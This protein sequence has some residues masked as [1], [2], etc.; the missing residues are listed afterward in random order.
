MYNYAHIGNLRTYI[1]EDVLRRTLEYHGYKTRHI[2]NLTDVDDKTIRDSR[3]AGKTLKEFTEFYAKEFFKDLAKL[4]ILRALKYPRATAHIPEMI[5]LINT[6]LKRGFAYKTDDG[7]YFDISKFK[8]YGKLSGVKKQNLKTGARVAADEY[9][10][11]EARDFALWKAKKPG[12]P[13]WEASFNSGGPASAKAMAGRPGWHIEC[14]AMSMKYLDKSFDI[15]AGAVDLLFP[16]HEDEIAQSEG[17]TGKQFVKYFIEGEHLLV[18]GKK[19]SKSL[20]NIYTMR[21]LAAKEFNPLDFR[22]FA[23]GAH[24]RTQLNFTW[25]A[26]AAAGQAR[27][28][29]DDFIRMLA[30]EKKRKGVELKP[31]KDN[32]QKSLANDI[33]T[34]RALAVIWDLIREYNKAPTK[35]DP[36][37]VKKLLIDFDRVLGLRLKE[38]RKFSVPEN[39]QKLVAIRETL[40]KEKRWQEADKIREKIKNLGFAIEDTA[41]G[42]LLRKQP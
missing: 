25:K 22:Y 23:L 42:P 37:A 2:M 5:A 40:R 6:L 16:H 27:K 26:L 24:Y 18:D 14:S 35:F 11:E 13:S 15:H 3:K 39:I 33:D 19:M 28:K 1:F 10:K 17:A 8:R 41:K 30:E 29:L 9:S 32:F 12:E 34:P 31:W 36:A 7:V 20:G 21:D 4:N 38:I